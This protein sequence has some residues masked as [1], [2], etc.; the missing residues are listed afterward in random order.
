MVLLFSKT[1]LFAWTRRHLR[2]WPIGK[3]IQ[4]TVVLLRQWCCFDFISAQGFIFFMLCLV[5]REIMRSSRWCGNLSMLYKVDANEFSDT[6][7]HPHPASQHV[8][9][10]IILA[11]SRYPLSFKLGSTAL[12]ISLH[13]IELFFWSLLQ[14]SK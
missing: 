3:I 11:S 2:R 14:L 13:R 12:S 7:V 5:S 8:T 6:L 10:P 4:C 1:K 9:V